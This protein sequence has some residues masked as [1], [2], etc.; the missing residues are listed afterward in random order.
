[1]K[2]TTLAI[3]ALCSTNAQEIP[4][5]ILDE[6]SFDYDDEY[7][8]NQSTQGSELASGP[9]SLKRQLSHEDYSYSS[10]YNYYDYSD[11]YYDSYDCTCDNYYDSYYYSSYDYYYSGY[12][13]YY[14]YNAAVEGE[15]KVAEES[16]EDVSGYWSI[17]WYAYSD[18]D[19]YSYHD[20]SNSYYYC[21]DYYS[22]C[23][24]Y[25]NNYYYSYYDYYDYGYDSYGYSDE[26]SCYEPF[27]WTG[28][29]AFLSGFFEWLSELFGGSY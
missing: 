15:D 3:A 20:Y 10:Y 13:Y 22:T 4:N 18:E 14:Y 29:L 26:C 8:I 17:Q 23:S 21:D 16:P 27:D 28:V 12:Y 5:T 19:T 24:S 11:S 6:V 9:R 25:S 1:M 2:Y 7:Y